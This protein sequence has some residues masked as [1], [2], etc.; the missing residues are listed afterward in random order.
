VPTGLVAILVLTAVELETRALARALSLPP[1]PSVPFLAF[2]HGTLR[3]APV[4]L[5]ACL[6]K[7]RWP[8]LVPV[9]DRPLVISAGVCGALDPALKVGDIV[10]SDSVINGAGTRLVIT[11][12]A[13]QRA[14]VATGANAHT[15]AMVSSSQVVATPEAKA[16]L[17]AATGGMAVDMESAV[18]LEVA[19]AHG[20]ASMIL[21]GVSD[22]ARATLPEEL[23]G[24][25]G[26]DGRLRSG[27]VLALARPGVL[28]GALRLRRATRQ[29]L[30]SVAGSLARLAA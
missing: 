10:V 19:A 14:A 30:L 12:S 17:R 23:M 21:R 13:G 27:G 8:A 20:C 29:A 28:A 3:I 18:I 15:G 11:A 25:M 26:A 9:S 6:L 5:R 16:A 7:D 1:L 2:G 24:L 22:D 4:G